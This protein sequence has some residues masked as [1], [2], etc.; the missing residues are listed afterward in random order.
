MGAEWKRWRIGQPLAGRKP[1]FGI[2]N[3]SVALK[4]GKQVNMRQT[5]L[6]MALKISKQMRCTSLSA[7]FFS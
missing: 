2:A 6:S 1:E 5:D 7:R 4:P 3:S